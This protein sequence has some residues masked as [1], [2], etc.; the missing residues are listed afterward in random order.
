M[1]TQTSRKTRRREGSATSVPGVIHTRSGETRWKVVDTWS[2]RILGSDAPD[3]FS[4]DHDPRAQRVKPGY[5]RCTWRVTVG[6]VD[7]FAKVIDHDSGLP[8][9]LRRALGMTSAEK[10]WRASRAAEGRGVPVPR[11]VG[12]GVR[13]GARPRS[14]LL[15]K[16]VDGAVTLWDAWNR[17]TRE[18]P[19]RRPSDLAPLAESAARLYAGAHARGFAHADGHPR[20]V[21]V[22]PDAT[23]ALSAVFI[24]VAGSSLSAG[25]ASYPH[26]VRSLTQL[27]HAFRQVT[28]RAERLRF[29]RKYLAAPPAG[30]ASPGERKLISAIERAEVVHAAALARQ[31]DRRLRGSGKYFTQFT[32]D[33]G[34]KVRAVL[35]LSRRHVFPEPSVTDWT[36][37]LW[38]ETLGPLLVQLHDPSRLKAVPSP[39]GIRLE[40]GRPRTLFDG[41]LWT[42]RGSPHRRAFEHC[43]RLRH[44]DRDCE[45]VLA[46]AEHRS[47]AG[48]VDR[49]VLIRPKEVP[50]PSDG[51]KATR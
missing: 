35:Q 40:I 6:D 13:S 42:T 46:C 33:G 18:T 15:S 37:E 10:E 51:A 8:D 25:P 23:G 30:H 43:H 34:W 2:D 41:L 5:R 28:T 48:M 19:Q 20:N 29:L 4:L 16:G 31:R 12:V 32:I 47:S 1:P 17:C 27:H 45:L 39:S 24:D 36:E 21:L 26:V 44:R 3:W 38:R 22:S 9:R 7:V 49:G 11:C 50:Q 14:V